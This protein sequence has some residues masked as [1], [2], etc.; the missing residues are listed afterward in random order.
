MSGRDSGPESGLGDGIGLSDGVRTLLESDAVVPS[1]DVGGRNVSGAATRSAPRSPLPL[2][3]VLL[4]VAAAALGAALGFWVDW[5]FP[6]PVYGAQLIL[7][8][9][10]SLVAAVGVLVRNLGQ[11][12]RTIAVSSLALL[13]GSVGGLVL[14]PPAIVYA[15][16]TMTLSVDL[17]EPMVISGVAV[18]EVHTLTDE[19]VINGDLG[20]GPPIEPGPVQVYVDAGHLVDDRVLVACLLERLIVEWLR[21]ERLGVGRLGIGGARGSVGHP[22]VVTPGARRPP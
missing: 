14:S 22:F 18:C 6:N 2:W 13:V 11:V 16:G 7:L 17:P 19:L 1:R 12:G 3:L 15:P 9:G 10:T 4:S 20:E 5:T 8:A 21:V